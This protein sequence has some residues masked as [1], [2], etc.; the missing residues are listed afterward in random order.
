MDY[1]NEIGAMSILQLG[2]TSFTITPHYCCSLSL[3][4]SLLVVLTKPLSNYIGSL[5]KHFMPPPFPPQNLRL[6]PIGVKIPTMLTRHS[7][8]FDVIV[9][10]NNIRITGSSIYNDEV[11][12][13]HRVVGFFNLN[14]YPLPCQRSNSNFSYWTKLQFVCR[15]KDAMGSFNFFHQARLILKSKGILY[16]LHFLVCNFLGFQAKMQLC[17]ILQVILQILTSIDQ[18][19]N[20][21]PS[22]S[23][24]WQGVLLFVA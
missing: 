11:L 4:L 23:S 5:R 15:T 12:L 20:I 24:D 2:A 8:L 18:S 10:V 19:G 1:L 13:I 9:S 16:M 21:L 6:L 7:S 14:F 22:N 17:R 3:S